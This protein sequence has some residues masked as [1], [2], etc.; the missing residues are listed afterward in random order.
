MKFRRRLLVTISSAILVGMTLAAVVS[1]LRSF[2]ASEE[3]M[4]GPT[5]VLK[6]EE[7]RS[8]SDVS[9]SK[10]DFMNQVFSQA[11]ED[12]QL[13]ADMIGALASNSTR[14]ATPLPSYY[15]LGRDSRGFPTANL[16]DTAPVCSSPTQT[17]CFT[18]PPG[19]LDSSG[20]ST[21]ASAYFIPGTQM[22][23]PPAASTGE[24]Q[25]DML[26]QMEL[27]S[28]LDVAFKAISA[29]NS[30]YLDMYFGFQSTGLFRVFPYSHRTSYMDARPSQRPGSTL[31]TDT[32]D[33]RQ[34]GWYYGAETAG[35]IAFTNPYP[36][37]TT[38]ELLI[39][40]AAPVYG[41]GGALLGV[42]GIDLSIDAVQQA[43]LGTQILDNGYGY[44][45]GPGGQ[46]IVHPRVD[47]SEPESSTD[48]QQVEFLDLDSTADVSSE[49]DSFDKTVTD[50]LAGGSKLT[51]FSK[52]GEPWVISYRP[53]PAAGYSL[54]LVVPEA[55]IL[56]PAQTV[57]ERVAGALTVQLIVFIA[58][59]AAVA[60]LVLLTTDHFVRRVVFPI[61][62]LAQATQ[63]LTRALA[64]RAD[65]KVDDSEAAHLMMALDINTLLPVE[66]A[67]SREVLLLRDTYDA[68]ISALRFGSDAVDDNDYPS[69]EKVY[70][71]SM[72]MFSKLQNEH[73]V[74]ICH[75]NLGVV[76]H[77]WWHASEKKD[78]GKLLLADSHYSSAIAASKD[79][80]A[81]VLAAHGAS[82][83]E[84]LV[85]FAPAGSLHDNDMCDR[86]AQRKFQLG[87]LRKDEGKMD[88]AQR[89]MEWA[90]RMDDLT[91]NIVGYAKR[92]AGLAELHI[93][94]GSADAGLALVMEMREDIASRFGKRG[95]RG[96]EE[97]K[98]AEG[99]K[100]DKDGGEAGKA[101]PR[102]ASSV[103]DEAVI[104]QYTAAALAATYTK[105]N[106]HRLAD[107]LWRQVLAGRKLP[108]DLHRR[109]LFS[110][111]AALEDGGDD[112][113]KVDAAIVASGLGGGVAKPK[114]VCFVIDY[115]GS[116]AGSR[117]TTARQNVQR[118]YEEFINDRDRV[119]L[120]K[121]S[122][123]V[124]TSFRLSA[125]SSD[126]DT[127][128]R[129]IAGLSRPT[130]GTSLY[131][132]VGS[133]LDMVPSTPERDQWIIVLTDGADGSSS[134]HTPESL[135]LQLA[136]LGINVVILS[137]GV[138]GTAVERMKTIVEGPT[139]PDQGLFIDVT[140]LSALDKAF[141]QVAELIS[142]GPDLS[143]ESY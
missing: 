24:L 16:A 40:V 89:L 64:G 75:A 63:T 76:Y 131:D 77:K 74:A 10:A 130:G 94:R 111:R 8:L 4:V 115:S 118:L 61:Q 34:R 17:G 13:L 117:I 36:D 83:L 135:K 98:A 125:K 1:G 66:T 70:K 97:R 53:V 113:D 79:A 72:D 123:R 48:I 92:M 133:A 96:A 99:G 32:Y 35:D 6:A 39:T 62:Q 142:G 128:R 80:F 68:L 122:H 105:L 109:A 81:S 22:Q 138:R 50:M 88:E 12:V 86:L 126:A 44:V 18:D 93:A 140:D 139:E 5:A 67:G 116:M 129:L 15:G 47:P 121:F 42:A 46:L 49:A 100:A 90:V 2:G 56:K 14:V 54:A 55:D 134:K 108:T 33:P 11:R 85:R 37:A 112:T 107:P 71:E 132:A 87:L 23:Q 21:D 141:E 78:E 136:G 120:I 60:A 101:A 25:T 65:P 20:V 51:T 102:S 28:V 110:L 104:E 38:G 52:G 137:I 29:G 103:L 57:R 124:T 73:G 69:A 3:W 30:K 26:V 27:S 9:Q 127:H 45:L 106:R 95:R 31:T 19:G 7:E 58:I 91:G 84:E 82:T 119:C 59:F 41:D 43:V 143:V 114:D